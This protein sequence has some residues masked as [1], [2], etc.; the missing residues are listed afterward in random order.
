MQDS[1]SQTN[2]DRKKEE[3]PKPVKLHLSQIEDDIKDEE[4]PFKDD[5]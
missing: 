1:D 5:E 3:K 4:W 2:K